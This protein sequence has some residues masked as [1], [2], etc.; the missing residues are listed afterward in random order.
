MTL[1]LLQKKEN[2]VEVQ[3]LD[4][5]K[6]RLS[7]DNIV[8]IAENR[9]KNSTDEGQSIFEALCKLISAKTG[10]LQHYLSEGVVQKKNTD[11]DKKSQ[12]NKGTEDSI[13]KIY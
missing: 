11:E 2:R 13:P 6:F 7:Y 4:V 1:T 8:D 3:L 10:N 9:N 5:D 12:F